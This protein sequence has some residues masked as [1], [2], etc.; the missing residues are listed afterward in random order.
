MLVLVLDAESNLE[1]G[2]DPKGKQ[3][4]DHRS[5]D[6]NVGE[7]SKDVKAKGKE[8]FHNLASY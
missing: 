2:S 4:E 8:I 7:N 3:E 5:K 1:P 6:R